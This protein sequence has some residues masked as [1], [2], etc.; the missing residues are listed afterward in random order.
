MSEIAILGGGPAGL[1]AAL[2]ARQRGHN[3]TVFEASSVVGG[4]ASSFEVAGQRVDL[5][6]HR[7]HPATDPET[8]S[9]IRSLTLTHS[10]SIYL[11]IKK[12]TNKKKIK[13]RNKKKKIKKKKKKK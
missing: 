1:I 12:K 6:S 7:L 3:V 9:L 8:L 10:L 11:K 13:K 4:M 5:G 2:R